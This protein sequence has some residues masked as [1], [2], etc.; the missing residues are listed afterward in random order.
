MF[1]GREPIYLQIAD[2]I[3]TVNTTPVEADPSYELAAAASLRFAGW[4]EAARAL[5]G[6]DGVDLRPLI[7]EILE[8]SRVRPESQTMRDVARVSGYY[9]KAWAEDPS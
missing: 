8:L 4:M 3:R 9:A 2:Q 7:Q 6:R 1:D 5:H